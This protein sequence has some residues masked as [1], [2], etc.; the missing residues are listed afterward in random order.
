MNRVSFQGERGAYSEA[1]AIS[2]F[3]NEIETIPCSTFADALKN[4][5]NGASDYSILPVEN[6][7]EGSVGESND[8]LLETDLNVIGEIY[9]RIHHCLI[10][11]GSIEDINTVYSHPQAL[12]QCRKF[13]Q[14]NSLKTIPSY[15]TAGSVKIIKNLNK[16][17]VACIASKNAAEIFDVP[18]IKEGVE[19]NANNYTRFLIFSK[20]KSD[21]TENSKT[22]II[23]SVKH[24]SGALYQIINEFYQHKINLTKIESRPNKNTAWEYNFYVDFEG[25]QDDSSV[26]DML[27]KLR[28]HS[29]F[30]KILGSY[31]IAKLD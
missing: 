13:I 18:I 29:T 26:K 3:G 17:N 2:F 31:P 10:G 5:E 30:L 9:H 28:S 12:G 4:T 24:E 11:T 27:E 14:E 25:H 20:E 6:S 8:L 19:D 22:S 1:A 16:N 15:D 21:E 23:F 7:L